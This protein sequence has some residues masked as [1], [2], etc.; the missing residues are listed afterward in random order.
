MESGTLFGVGHSVES[1]F[2]KNTIH[3]VYNL[4]LGV[5]NTY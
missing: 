1:N 5:I 4:A 2:A 3:R